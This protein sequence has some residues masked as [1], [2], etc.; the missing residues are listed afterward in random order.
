MDRKK[1]D[2]KPI[3]RSCLML[4]EKFQLIKDH[5][6]KMSVEKLKEK[7]KCGK[8]AVY[9]I[10][11]NKSVIV[12]EYLSTQNV[13]AK[14]KIR[15][16]K[17][18]VINELTFNWLTQALSKNLPISGSLVQEKAKEIAIENGDHEFKASN[19]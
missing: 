9:E 18:D 10:I 13:G 5:D 6:D 1:G 7:Y 19:G 8:T 2:N 16:S 3:Q 15:S 4:E 17:F 12:D 11:K 14:M